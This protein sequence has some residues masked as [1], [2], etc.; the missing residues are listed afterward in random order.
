MHRT[1]SI[2]NKPFSRPRTA[3]MMLA[4]AAAAIGV[5]C[6]T[7]AAQLGLPATQADFEC[8]RANCASYFMD[9]NGRPKGCYQDPAAPHHNCLGYCTRCNG[10]LQF[11]YCKWNE[12]EE[13]TTHS[14]LGTRECGTT[15]I[16]HCRGA[17]TIPPPH[18]GFAGCNCVAPGPEN[19][20]GP[21]APAGGATCV[22]SLCL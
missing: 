6:F 7:A 10:N 16:E 5:A 17:W 18:G 20:L 8:V 9:P 15:V 13:C 11:D 14:D 2:G 21:G 19:P 1:I 12:G 22:I 3:R 4:S